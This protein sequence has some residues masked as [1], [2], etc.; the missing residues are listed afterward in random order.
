MSI[1]SIG[2]S[3]ALA[4]LTAAEAQLLINHHARRPRGE[5]LDRMREIRQ[6]DPFDSF[7][8]TPSEAD[9]LDQVRALNAEGYAA[10][11]DAQDALEA[12]PNKGA[13]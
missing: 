12:M 9:V 7:V 13:A 4:V 10:L 2:D 5:G 1:E 3:V 11:V 8:L 6:R